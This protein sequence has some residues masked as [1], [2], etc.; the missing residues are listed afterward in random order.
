M[1]IDLH[2]HT[3]MCCHAEGEM[4][5]YVQA[6]ISKKIGVMGFAEHSPWMP[7]QHI[8]MALSWDEAPLYVQNVKKLQDQYDREEKR[9]IKILLG[10]EMDFVPE[11]LDHPREFCQKYDFDYVI[12]SVHYI[13]A[14]GFDQDTQKKKF[15][16]DSIREIYER[17]FDLVKQLVQTGIFDIMGHVDLVKKFGYFPEQ[18]WDD[19]QEET[20]RILGESD[21]VVELNASGMDK[22]VGEFYPGPDFL[23]RLKKYGVPMTLS[24]DAHKPREVGRY[25]DKAVILLKETGYREVFMFSKRKKIPVSLY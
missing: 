18:G 15:E 3:K 21:M 13:G 8:K 24:S 7:E 22:P 1:L 9:R 25:F 16:L 17:Y 19:L 6:A 5:E 11:L 23:K 2:N 20:A 12:G 14:W 10:M 4:E